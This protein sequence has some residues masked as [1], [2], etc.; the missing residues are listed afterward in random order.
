MKL[1]PLIVAFAFI[2][3]LLAAIVNP[4]FSFFVKMFVQ[5]I[6]AGES[7]FKDYLFLG[8]MSL[9]F[10]I[11]SFRHGPI[12][13]RR[14]D[15]CTLTAALAGL[16]VLNF[17]A[18]AILM[19]SFGFS[20]HDKFMAVVNLEG[21][22]NHL[23]HMHVLKGSLFPLVSML[24]K[25]KLEQLSDP[26]TPFFFLLPKWISYLAGAFMGV[27]FVSILEVF[28]RRVRA[29]TGS[30]F[31]VFTTLYGVSSFAVFKSMLDGGPLSS[32]MAV[33]L[34][35]FIVLTQ[36]RKSSLLNLGKQGLF[37]VSVA[38]MF[39]GVIYLFLK[40]ESL[41]VFF[42]NGWLSLLFIIV[43]WLIFFFIASRSS[44]AGFVLILFLMLLVTQS[45]TF[46][47]NHARAYLKTV[48]KPGQTIYAGNFHGFSY[49][50]PIGYEING[51]KIHRFEASE[52]TTILDLHRELGIPY[53][54]HEI[55]VADTTC[56]ENV[57]YTI[58]GTLLTTNVP[59]TLE[60]ISEA[61]T[62]F[63]VSPV[64]GKPNAYRYQAG[65]KG[66]VPNSG[67]ELVRAQAHA[68]GFRRYV[69]VF[70]KTAS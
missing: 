40:P 32:E 48:I 46:Y 70:D 62:Y 67:Q 13:E 29:W 60:S 19:R 18:Y 63:Y 47:W 4:D 53:L 44:S 42:R 33:Y 35:V 25:T 3:G 11:A 61:F 6:A 54:Y 12:N 30:D 20:L 38:F 14:W 55:N 16:T 17:V 52:E 39:Y 41:P 5:F 8:W 31:W 57:P 23:E 36:N 10:F 56:L 26:G 68:M 24:G 34:P 66:C 58:G 51:M 22:Y 65:V 7:A 43:V 50:T 2:V 21:S 9:I 37:F 69:I 1:K 28:R 27:A 59:V 15:V 45:S 49:K 64:E